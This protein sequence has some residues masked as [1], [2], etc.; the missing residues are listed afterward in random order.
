MVW[1]LVAMQPIYVASPPFTCVQSPFS[2]T[3]LIFPLFLISLVNVPFL[4]IEILSHQET[5]TLK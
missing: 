3:L 1:S 5:N 4:C 2:L